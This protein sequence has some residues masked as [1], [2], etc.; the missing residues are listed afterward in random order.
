MLKKLVLSF[1]LFILL[2]LRHPE[3]VS[4][5]D[6]E[7]NSEVNYL[8]NKNGYIE[9]TQAI[10]ITN[11]SSETQ[12]SELNINLASTNP[13]NISVRYSE[14][15][16]SFEFKDEILKV[17]LNKEIVGEGSSQKIEI[18]FVDRSLIDQ[19][20][21]VT[22]VLIPKLS[23]QNIFDAYLVRVI[24]PKEVGK[25]AFASPEPK[26]KLDR[27]D[28]LT[29]YYKKEDLTD[30]IR[31]TFGESQV[32]SFDIT[33]H[34]E[35]PLVVSSKTEIAI[36]PDTS[37]Q[38]VYYEQLKPSPDKT[39]QDEEG[40]WLAVYELM[41]RERLD[42]QAIGFVE[43][44][45][46]SIRRSAV[47]Q[48]FLNKNLLPSEYWQTNDE[49]IKEL[50]LELKTPENIY[51]YV[52][53]RLNYDYK[54]V[55]PT[56]KRIGA[57]EAL[58]NPN[59]AICTEFTDLFITI[60]RASG[61]PA[62]EINGFAYTDNTN[63]QPLSLVADVLHAWPEYWDGSK[64]VWIAVDPTWGNTSGVDYFHKL[65]LKH[66]TFVKHGLS[67]TKPI[68]PGSYKLGTNPQKDVFIAIAELPEDIE[69]R[70]L[71]LFPENEEKKLEVENKNISGRKIIYAGLLVIIGLIII[72]FI[73]Y[74][75]YKSRK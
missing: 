23:S 3:L 49:N 8:I 10:D 73:V 62:R 59:Q 14:S 20:A 7:L 56:A 68:S 4:G 17:Y 34:L 61:I 53:N 26:S 19:T 52:V 38:T 1:I 51:N 35:N 22:E 65:D 70:A 13:E 30:S 27:E 44:Y 42:V 72:L 2:I 57:V 39:Y 15:E 48:D 69:S 75:I 67:A 66:F 74:E 32:F 37:T 12:A 41:P 5:S 24:V 60:A 6:F 50:A 47:T 55:S 16:L 45:P 28:A 54:K 40:N 11:K 64:Q 21:S 46:G 58:K 63:L 31:L 43:I 18:K 71:N 29:L 25:L 33:Y 9:V 36:P